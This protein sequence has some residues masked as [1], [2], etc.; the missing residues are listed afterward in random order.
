MPHLCR[1][2]LTATGNKRGH[3]GLKE[4]RQNDPEHPLYLL[5]IVI[6]PNLVVPSQVVAGAIQ[7]KVA[8]TT[9]RERGVVDPAVINDWMQALLTA[10]GSSNLAVIRVV[11]D[12]LVA[13]VR[14]LH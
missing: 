14:T 2:T 5:Y 11:V 12:A 1:D 7:L 10:L 13:V 6:T 4:F 9:L 8:V 3:N